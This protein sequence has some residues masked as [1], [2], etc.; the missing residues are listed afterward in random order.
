MRL[1][2]PLGP[3]VRLQRRPEHRDGVGSSQTEPIAEHVL[4]EPF[5][6]ASGLGL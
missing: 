1:N 2:S 3:V 4:V 5:V 6:A